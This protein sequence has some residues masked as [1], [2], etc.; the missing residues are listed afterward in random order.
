MK[1][2]YNLC[3]D[4]VVV[5]EPCNIYATATLY[6]GVSVGA[7]TEIG[8]EVSIGR[9]TRVGAGCF[10][11]AGVNIGSNCFIGPHVCF[12]N[13]MY[14]PSPQHCWEKTEVLSNASIGAN[15][16]IRPGV[17]IGHN[18]LVGMGSVVTKSI[19]DD[20]VWAGVPAK[21]IRRKHDR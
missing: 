3:F 15:V 8:D 19:P 21:F 2:L 10:I 7:F 4:K 16:S 17:V 1:R 11:P 9:D 5:W 14:P 13:D 6:P 20:E 18:S 12:S